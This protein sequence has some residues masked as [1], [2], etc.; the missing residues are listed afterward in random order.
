MTTDLD[1]LD[2]TGLLGLAEAEV[3]TRRLAGADRLRLLLAW[4]DL[5][6]DDPQASPGAVP[7]SR[8]GDRLI[9]LGGE[10]TPQ[11]AELCWAELA[12]A[13][14]TGVIALR[15]QAGQ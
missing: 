6:A 3:A 8:G 15:N 11:V 14:A 12:I 13:L 1:A 10:G 7:V 4:A 5:H 9:S 2:A